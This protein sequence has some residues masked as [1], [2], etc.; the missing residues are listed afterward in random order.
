[1]YTKEGTELYV[2]EQIRYLTTDGDVLT[3]RNNIAALQTTTTDQGQK[4]ATNTAN[5]ANNAAA[6]NDKADKADVYSKTDA[7]TTFATKTELNAKANAAALDT[8]A[9]KT[10]V[11]TKLDGKADKATTLAGYGINDAYTKDATNTAITTKVNEEKNARELKDAELSG[12]I[13]TLSTTVDS[14]V[15]KTD[16][17]TTLGNYYTQA[18]TNAAIKNAVDDEKNARE[19]A[20]NGEVTNRN[21]AIAD[22]IAVE[23]T[24]RDAAIT[25]AK[26]ELKEKV[27]EEETKRKE[28]DAKLEGK[29][30]ENTTAINNEKAV[31][32]AA[33]TDLSKRIGTVTEDGKYIKKSATNNVSEN[34]KVLDTQAK[35]NAEAIAQEAAKRETAV[36]NAKTE[37]E[38]RFRRM[39][40]TSKTTKMKLLVLMV[41]L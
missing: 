34:L 40:I 23:E 16:L 3:N 14:K 41:N 32:E 19:N 17:N 1:M 15:S 35:T 6:L 13:D 25:N 31:R 21:K 4:I 5:I 10:Y 2:A 24:K 12:R 20:I 9:D 27:T 26:T 30:T 7:D 11:D 22:A 18:E 8:K 36:T 29:I 37:L 28:E 39:R 38:K 33:D